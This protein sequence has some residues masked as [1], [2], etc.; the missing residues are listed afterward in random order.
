VTLAALAIA[1][2]VA[3]VVDA[4]VR[5]PSVASLVGA[6]GGVGLL[7]LVYVLWRTDD[8]LL[9][10]ALLMA[11]IGYGLALV[12]H[13][14]GV[15][16]GAPLVGAGLLLCGELATWSLDERIAIRAERGLVVA[17]AGAVGAL[18]LGGLLI[19]G[20]VVAV[21]AAPTGGGLAW[22]TIGAAAVVVLLVLVTRLARS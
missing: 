13:G 8:E 15:D 22:T 21:A 9:P 16:D 20:L 7:M 4:A 1:A 10:W 14:G 5:A 6:L 17:R 3:V 19:G 11:G 12:V 2:Y 18:V